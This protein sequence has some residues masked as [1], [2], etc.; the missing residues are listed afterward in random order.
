M[1][2]KASSSSTSSPSRAGE[3]WKQSQHQRSI[4]N[5]QNMISN[6]FVFSLP[7]PLPDLRLFTQRKKTEL[8]GQE[9]DKAATI[10]HSRAI[11]RFFL[12]LGRAPKIAF[13]ISW[14]NF[15]FLLVLFAS[16]IDIAKCLWC[17]LFLFSAGLSVALFFR[18]LIMSKVK[19]NSGR[20]KHFP[21]SRRLSKASLIILIVHVTSD[22]GG[23]QCKT[24]N[25]KKQKIKAPFTFLIRS[26]L[27][28]T[29]NLI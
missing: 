7:F 21:F 8:E 18:L 23:K 13:F 14:N 15:I 3:I 11:T 19:W 29:F 16:A 6:I 4:V 26:N 9:E 17:A 27:I 10:D 2:E 5:L 24:I 28:F 1:H 22:R 25:I 12:G 20:E